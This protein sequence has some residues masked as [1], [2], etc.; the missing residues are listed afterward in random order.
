VQSSA[1]AG[2]LGRVAATQGPGLIGC[3]LTTFSAAKAMV[4][5]L[6]LPFVGVHH[7]LG[8]IN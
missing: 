3:L 1:S 7:A 8:H 4:W 5:R 2:D 6:G